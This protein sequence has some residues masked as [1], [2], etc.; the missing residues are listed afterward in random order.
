MIISICR[1]HPYRTWYS[2]K[3]SSPGLLMS[4]RSLQV[5]AA[6][7]ACCV[8]PN[9]LRRMEGVENFWRISWAM[10]PGVYGA[11]FQCLERD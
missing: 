11:C 8:S 2:T 1:T 3:V 5:P 9:C 6:Y 4:S 10:I 7:F